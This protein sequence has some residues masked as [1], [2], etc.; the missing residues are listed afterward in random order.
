M[1]TEEICKVRDFGLLREGAEVYVSKSELPLP[2]WW[3]APESLDDSKVE[4]IMKA[5]C[6]ARRS[7]IEAEFHAY[8]STFN[9]FCFH[10][11]FYHNH[12]IVIY[13]AQY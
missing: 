2:L 4:W 12:I 9:I 3:M 5:Y 1:G 6:R 7:R 11:Q 10:Y 8:S 13:S